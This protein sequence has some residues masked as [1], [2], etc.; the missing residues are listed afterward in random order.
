MRPQGIQ[1]A[2]LPHVG[3]VAES[4]GGRPGTAPTAS[5]PN[6]RRRRLSSLS[7]DWRR[8]RREG[9]E[10][11]PGC[12]GCSRWAGDAP[13]RSMMATARRNSAAA[14]ASRPLR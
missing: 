2:V 9:S 4:G 13:T 14:S 10:S 12:T 8:L 7:R 1:V 11:T 6:D 5:D 3:K